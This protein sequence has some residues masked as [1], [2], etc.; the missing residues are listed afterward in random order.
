MRECC[1]LTT[2]VCECL[3]APTNPSFTM[4]VL[5]LLSD[6]GS[7]RTQVS[8]CCVSMLMCMLSVCVC[9]LFKALLHFEGSLLQLFAKETPIDLTL[10]CL[11][12]AQKQDCFYRFIP[13]CL[14][15]FYM[16]AQN[17]PP[18]KKNLAVLT[19]FAQAQCSLLQLKQHQLDILS[20]SHRNYMKITRDACCP[21]FIAHFTSW[22]RP[23]NL[24]HCKLKVNENMCRLYTDAFYCSDWQEQSPSNTF[25]SNIM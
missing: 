2:S 10:C 11:L 16:C 18:R 3:R 22:S 15:S 21:D 23:I 7:F 25:R 4:P 8:C 17:S 14:Y 19:N 5:K 1:L 20:N 9:L 24:R 13:N 12:D 6:P